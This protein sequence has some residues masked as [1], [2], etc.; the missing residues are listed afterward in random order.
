MA[1]KL[2]DGVFIGDAESSQD[3][4]FMVANKIRAI[5]NLC[6]DRVPNTWERAGVAYLRYVGGDGGTGRVGHRPRATRSTD[7][8]S[9][10]CTTS[11][12]DR[13]TYFSTPSHPSTPLP[14]TDPRRHRSLP[15]RAR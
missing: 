7:T 14:D 13:L 4:E 10:T 9:R 1:S 8:H 15:L 12:S 3:I 6:A 5:I 11:P 2:K